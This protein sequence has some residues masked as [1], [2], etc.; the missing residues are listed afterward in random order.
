MTQ[1]LLHAAAAADDAGAI[2]R[3]L[4][5]GA[6][7]E[8]RDGSG[9]TALLVATRANRIAA[10]KALIEAGADVN[11]VDG[12]GVTPRAHARASGYRDIEA[13]LAAAGAH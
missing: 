10:A 12:N 9:A 1:T 2:G 13:L 4:A 7:I 8:A 3:L 11:L 6:A 5:A